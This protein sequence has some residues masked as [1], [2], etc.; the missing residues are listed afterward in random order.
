[1]VHHGR[2]R[3]RRKAVRVAILDPD[4]SIFLLRYKNEEVGVHWAMPGGGIHPGEILVQAARREVLEETG[5]DDVDLGPPLWTWEHDF[6]YAGRPI[7]QFEVILLA[8]GARQEPRGDLPSGHAAD[9]IL[10][11][12]WW[13]AAELSHCEDA[14]WPPNLDEL[15]KKLQREGPP[16][17]P[18][19]L[20]ETFHDDAPTAP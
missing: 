5:W 6:T 12:R 19:R 17:S 18:T 1:L 2:V 16:R 15:L 7:R 13:S 4:A 9:R 14:L 10:S 8:K 3:L 20:P 11:W